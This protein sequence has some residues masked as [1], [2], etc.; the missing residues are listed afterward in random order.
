MDKIARLAIVAVQQAVN[1]P[2]APVATRLPRLQN[3]RSATRPQSMRKPDQI[4]TTL[5]SSMASTLA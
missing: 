2:P 1:A 4:F 5:V 3:L